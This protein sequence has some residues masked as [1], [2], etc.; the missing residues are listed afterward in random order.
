MR[1]VIVPTVSPIRTGVLRISSR[2]LLVLGRYE[3]A[4]G[5]EDLIPANRLCGS[6]QG[7]PRSSGSARRE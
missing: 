1:C 7:S 3:Y 2:V 5:S 4:C 6:V